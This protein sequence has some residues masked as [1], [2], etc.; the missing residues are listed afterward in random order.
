MMLLLTSGYCVQ[1]QCKTCK[2]Q[3]EEHSNVYLTAVFMSITAGTDI[4]KI[5]IINLFKDNWT[6][7]AEIDCRILLSLQTC[8]EN[9]RLGQ[10]SRSEGILDRIEMNRDYRWLQSTACITDHWRSGTQKE[11]RN[12][13]KKNSR[14]K[15]VMIDH[16]VGKSSSLR[17]KGKLFF[18]QF[19]KWLCHVRFFS[20]EMERHLRSTWD[21]TEVCL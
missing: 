11:F 10:G 2:R 18:R 15:P 19:I 17:W 4:E 6:S 21:L 14:L 13:L 7:G 5:F 16:V 8:R 20:W 1:I 9:N 3:V 12:V